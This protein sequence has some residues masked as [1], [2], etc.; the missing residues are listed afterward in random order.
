MHKEQ[1]DIGLGI[2]FGAAVT[3]ARDDYDALIQLG[4]AATVLG[5]GVTEQCAQQIVDRR[6]VQA[7]DL[8]TGSAAQVELLELLADRFQV[9]ARGG[10]RSSDAVKFLNQRIFAA[11]TIESRG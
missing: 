1:V 8:G 5:I 6:G 7:D 11:E 4:K 9:Q 10:S 3:A 2:Q